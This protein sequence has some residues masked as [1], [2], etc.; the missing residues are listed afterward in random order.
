[1]S[2]FCLVGFVCLRGRILSWMC[3]EVGED[4]G[5]GCEGENIEII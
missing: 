3:R 5:G 1:M 4:S 2:Q